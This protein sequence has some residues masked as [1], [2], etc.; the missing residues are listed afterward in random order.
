MLE[1]LQEWAEPI[2]F[3]ISRGLEKLVIKYRTVTGMEASW[4]V[5][6]MMFSG[7][8]P[9]HLVN[10]ESEIHFFRDISRPIR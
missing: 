7:L 10:R 4:T 6:E 9:R 2:H 1:L 8:S 3:G 5:E